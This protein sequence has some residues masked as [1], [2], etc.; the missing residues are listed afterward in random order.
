MEDKIW[1]KHKDGILRFL[2]SDKF[3]ATDLK[4][5]LDVLHH[6]KDMESSDEWLYIPF[7]AWAKLE[8]MEDYLKLMTNSNTEDVSDE[9]AK[10]YHADHTEQPH[11]WREDV[12]NWT[13]LDATMPMFIRENPWILTHDGQCCVL[14]VVMMTDAMYAEITQLRAEFAAE[15]ELADRMYGALEYI[16]DYCLAYPELESI[17]AVSSSAIEYADTQRSK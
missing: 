16:D 7:A 10:A 2:S 4:T 15:R 13:D 3:S 9:I 8:Q 12:T 5:A 11:T 1:F 17:S 14:D 6:F